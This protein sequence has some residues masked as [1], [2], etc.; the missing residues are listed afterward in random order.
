[1]T[2]LARALDGHDLVARIKRHVEEYKSGGPDREAE[3]IALCQE[4][5][6]ATDGLVELWA[7][8][9]KEKAEFF[10]KPSPQPAAEAEPTVEPKVSAFAELRK[11]KE[12][13]AQARIAAKPEEDGQAVLKRLLGMGAAP[14][15]EP[16]EDAPQ[17]GFAD[18][19]DELDPDTEAVLSPAAPYD[20]AREYARRFCFR[21]GLVAM[22]YWH[23]K[24][25]QWNGRTYQEVNEDDLRST[26]F[27]FL[28]RSYKHEL[29]KEQKKLDVVR[30][31][32]KPS[33]ANELI[34]C[35]KAGLTLPADLHP[36]VWLDTRQRA[37]EVWVFRN[38]VLDIRTEKL[39]KPSPRLWVHG[40]VDFDWDPVAERP[41]WDR[42]LEDVFP[43][44]EESKVFAEEWAGYCKTEDIRFQKGALLVGDERTGKGTYLVVLEALVGPERYVSLSFNDWLK[45]DK[46]K[47]VLIGK[48]VGAFPDVRLR[49]PKM[50]GQSRDSGGLAHDSVEL[51]LKLT[52]GDKVTISR[53]Y[54]GAWEGKVPIKI[55]LA[56]NDPPNFNDRVLGTRF[57]KVA[58]LVSFLD[59]EDITLPTRLL[60]E[61][62]GIA[63]RALAG[64]KRACARGRFIQPKTGLQLK[65]RMDD[66]LDPFSQFVRETFIIDPAGTVS[67]R[68]FERSW[69]EWC[70][71]N[72]RPDL[73]KSIHSKTFKRHLR[74]IPGLTGLDVTRAGERF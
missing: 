28:D 46:S 5:G 18:D 53:K 62:P 50:Y 59:R 71:E 32:P 54:I 58:F 42:Y 45:D 64:Y 27:K 69:K 47:E 1:M 2:D 74:A 10:K 60:A 72:S 17:G 16:E 30:F 13:Q 7:K 36:P 61:L 55:T 21:E 33:H 23:E 48:T 56:S 26:V 11:R 68:L 73:A 65:E 38:G 22:W 51:L 24:L 39:M 34:D 63:R 19:L 43:G 15:E 8:S 66:E 67:I 35:L 14:Q 70:E 29:N 9:R 20:N 37:T 4:V 31:R 57:I 6:L 3:D 12:A 40:A 25:W 49:K 44:D 41:T 52:A